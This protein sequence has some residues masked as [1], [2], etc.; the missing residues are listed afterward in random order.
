MLCKFHFKKQLLFP[1]TPCSFVTQ[2]THSWSIIR[3]SVPVPEET[4]FRDPHIVHLFCANALKVSARRALLPEGKQLHA[5]LIKFGFCHVLS[6]QDQIL[7]VYLKCMEAEN[8][9]KLFEELPLRNVVSWNIL[10]HGIVGCGN[11]IENYSNRQLCFSYF[12]RMLLETVVPDG[13]TF[14]GLIGVC[15]KFHDIAM[16]FQLHCFAVKFGLDLDCFVGSVLVD[17]YAKCGLVENAKRA[18]HV[19]PRPDL[20]MWNVMISCY[21]LNWLPEEAFGMFNL[22]R[23]GGA[24]GDEFVGSPRSKLHSRPKF[25]FFYYFI[26]LEH[27]VIFESG[28]FSIHIQPIS[29]QI[30]LQPPSVTNHV[31]IIYLTS[32]NFISHVLTS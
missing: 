9:E 29:L 25:L 4:H 12:K 8:V 24:N 30:Y 14:N 20:V 5:H 21:A 32:D 15:V 2:C 3:A 1:L 31:P 27:L 10:I 16:G 22:M 6:L 23:L 11:A 7:G 13:T 19:V 18:F 17:L 28:A 26:I